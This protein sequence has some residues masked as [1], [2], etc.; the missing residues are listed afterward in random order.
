MWVLKV[1][2]KCKRALKNARNVA[3]NYRGS[4]R[5]FPNIH[6]RFGK[7]KLIAEALSWNQASHDFGFEAYGLGWMA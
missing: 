2:T 4:H 3:E 5:K 6:G 1:Q 7:P